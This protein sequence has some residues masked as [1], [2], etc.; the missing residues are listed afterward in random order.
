MIVK[1]R[2]LL[3][4][5]FILLAFSLC[6]DIDID[7][8]NIGSEKI[9]EPKPAKK[10]PFSFDS[11]IDVI[12]PSKINKGCYK[13]DKI[14]YAE[15]EA[16]LGMVFYYCPTYTEGARVAVAFSPTYLKWHQNPWF[17]QD[18]F[19]TVSF[20]FVGFS[21][22]IDRWFWRTQLTANFDAEKWSGKYTSYDLLFWGRY[23]YCENIGIHFG[24]FVETGL[25]MDR[26]YPVIG[27]DWQITRKWKLSLVYPVNISLLYALSPKWSIG[28]AGRLFNSRFRV[29]HSDYSHKPLVRYTNVGAEFIVKYETDLMTANLHAGSTLGGDF[30]VASRKNNHARHYHIDPSA[31]VGGEIE[32]KF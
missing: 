19:N 11:H 27:F 24:F 26:V 13:G 25:R 32:V 21:K 10:T 4:S 2:V 18:H 28:A 14:H 5:C 9:S 22:R 3:T 31:Y 7:P 30:R 8:Q 16:E 17:D 23:A 15:S 6:A 29:H 12:G 20:S 1:I